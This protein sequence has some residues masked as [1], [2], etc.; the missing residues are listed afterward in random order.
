M[1]NLIDFKTF[2]EVKK[3]QLIAEKLRE[4]TGLSYKVII[5]QTWNDGSIITEETKV[6]I[7]KE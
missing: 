5:Q 3:Q 1:L 2:L 4:E 7:S 6:F